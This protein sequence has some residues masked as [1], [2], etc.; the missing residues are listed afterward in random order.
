MKQLIILFLFTVAYHS[1]VLCQDFEIVWQQCYG[2]SQEERPSDILAVEGGYFIVGGTYSYDGDISFNQGSSDAWVIKIDSIGNILW[3]NTYGGSNGEFWRRILP[4]PDN[5]YYLLGASG[6]WDGD[7]SYDPYPG[8]N[9]LWIAKIDSVGNLIWEKIIG[10]WMIDMIESAALAG[11]GGVVVFGW[12]GSQDGEVTVNY[13]MYDM[14][15]VKLN[16]DG[17]IEWDKSFGT[18]DF[19][20][21]HAIIS[22][23]DGGFLIG[24]ASTIGS[25]GNLTCLPYNLKAMAIL[26]K[27]DSM[28]NIEWQNCYGGSGDDGIYGLLELNDGYAFTAFTR[29]PDGDVSG[30]HGGTD[31]WFVRLDIT[32]N[33]IWEQCYGGS[34]SEIAHH[35]FVNSNGDFTIIGYTK[36][37][38]GDVSGNNSVG[39][40]N[41]IWVFRIDNQGLLLSQ[42]CFGGIGNEAVNGHK[43]GVAQ[44]SDNNFVIATITNYGPSF[45]VGCTPYGGNGD[46][47]Y[48][49]FE[50]MLDDTLNVIEPV[51][52]AS[53][54]NVYPNPATTELWLQLPENMPYAQAQI[55][56]FSPT[57]RLLYKA[58]PT[59]QF[60]KIETA[61]LPAGLYLIRIWDGKQWFGEKVV[62]RK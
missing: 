2:G 54:I 20:Y 13:G 51:E 14:W 7:I 61:H 33:I 41:D 35:L 10:G 23:S 17:D 31:I 1:S 47:D 57:G 8:S 49:V 15:L 59:S 3:E 37:N 34:D 30:Y 53:E 26:I 12:T 44:K 9:D 46:I 5:C 25:G 36:S 48:W 38:N 6:S 4:A 32:G 24:G 16:S 43:F 11:D 39:V 56:L 45:D 58:Q 19:D 55:E 60:H 22:T 28:G 62:V 29:S 27:L 40:N 21:G 18:D 50:I 42:Q 52:S